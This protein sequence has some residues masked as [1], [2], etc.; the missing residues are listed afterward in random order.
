VFQFFSEDFGKQNNRLTLLGS[1]YISSI[2]QPN[3]YIEY[4]IPAPLTIGAIY[5]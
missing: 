3:R 5:I 1:N 2:F 4:P